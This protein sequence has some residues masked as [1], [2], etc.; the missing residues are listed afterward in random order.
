[1][2]LAATYPF[3]AEFSLLRDLILHHASAELEPVT[4][5]TMHYGLPDF[6]LTWHNIRVIGLHPS[7]KGVS[8]LLEFRKFMA[9]PELYD[10]DAINQFE[11]A[12]GTL[13]TN[14]NGLFVLRNVDDVDGEY[15]ETYIAVGMR[16][17][18][19]YLRRTH[20]SLA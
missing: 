5:V 14:K 7:P 11:D 16:L 10:A 1:M 6:R 17:H 15:L 19:D 9:H 18:L 2:E 20:P 12:C 4:G 3:Y 13:I 8:L